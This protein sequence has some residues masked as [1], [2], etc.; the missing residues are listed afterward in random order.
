M[1]LC[2]PVVTGLTSNLPWLTDNDDSTCNYVASGQ[3]LTVNLAT[4]IPITWIRFV[5]GETG[6]TLD[7]REEM[8]KSNV[9]IFF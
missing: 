4:D 5:I 9:L 8:I 7:D 6:N 2:L 3:M 1:S